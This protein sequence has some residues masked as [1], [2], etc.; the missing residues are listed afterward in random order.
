MDY[1]YLSRKEKII[2][3]AIDLLDEVGLQGFTTKKIAQ[4]HGITEAAIYKQFASKSDIIS[5]IIERY[6]A[7]DQV[8]FNTIRE[9]S[10]S[11]IEGLFY[12]GKTY[13]E[14]YHNYRQIASMPSLLD[15]FHSSEDGHKR[16]VEILKRRKQMICSLIEQAIQEGELNRDTD[17][18]A[19]TDLLFSAIWGT[20]FL[21]KA[22]RECFNLKDRIKRVLDIAIIINRKEEKTDG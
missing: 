15:I 19:L 9:S 17:T 7:F 16:M 13:A 5:A 11:G 20:V 10:M 18:I 1:S 21:W 8:I 6:G 4:R 12:L 2:I 22:E 3:T 14:Y